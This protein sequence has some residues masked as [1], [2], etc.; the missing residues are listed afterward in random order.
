MAATPNGEYIVV[1]A[2][3]GFVYLYDSLADEFVQG[4]QV[5]TNPIQGFYGPVAAGPRG[6]YFLA[7]GTILNQ[8][9]TPVANAGS[10]GVPGPV[11][12]G[13]TPATTGRPI[14]AVAQVGATTFVR[15]SQP[16][17]ANANAALTATDVSAVELVDVNTGQTLRTTTTLEGPISTAV[18]TQRVNLDGRTLAVDAAGSTVYALTTSGL[19]ISTLDAPNV[20]DRPVPNPNGIVSISSYV[21]AMAPGS[22]ISIFGRNL[23]DS[24]TA[25]T[26]PLPTLL[27]GA[28]VTLNNQPL[29]LLMTS[30]GQINAQIPPEM[31]AGRYNLIVRGVDKKAASTAQSITIAKYAPSV[32]ADPASKMAAVYHDDGRPVTKDSPAKR[33]EPLVL[34]ATGLGLTKGGKVTAGSPAPSSPLAVTDDVNVFFGDPRIK[35]AG[36]IVDWSGLT[37]GF[38]GV[39]QVN[40][41]VP[42][43]HLRGNALPVTLRIGGIDSQKTGPA[44]PVIAVD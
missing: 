10:V 16:F 30:S 13:E 4:R 24:G 29:P 43:A 38:I 2:G 33:D 26:T 18:G 19:S 11:R 9:L 3:N 41:R 14:S 5:F 6:Q 22:L 12:P 7:N 23:A 37:P 17:R 25:S 8:A 42:G 39:Y 27:G 28:C 40:L 35:E 36:I 1:L 44:V 15:F 21:P 34:Y 31:A 32:I 20:A